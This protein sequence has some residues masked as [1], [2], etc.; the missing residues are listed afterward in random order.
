MRMT[1]KRL[2]AWMLTLMMIFSCVSASAVDGNVVDYS[3]STSAYDVM[4]QD[5]STSENITIT[6]VVDNEYYVK[7]PNSG[8]T[9]LRVLRTDAAAF[10][11]R[12]L[13]LVEWSGQPK[14]WKIASTGT[15]STYSI[16]SGSTLKDAGVTL[17]ALDVFNCTAVATPQDGYRY[18]S[19]KSWV[20]ES[21][22]VCNNTTVFTED[23]T[24]YLQL[25]VGS[26]YYTI[27]FVCG[28][29]NHSIATSG[30]FQLGQTLAEN[31]MTESTVA[32]NKFTSDFCT[33]GPASNE[34]LSAWQL[35]NY[36]T[37]SRVNLT[38]GL[39]ITSDYATTQYGS[40]IKAYAVWEPGVGVT[41]KIGNQYAT[42]A[43]ETLLVKPGAK[44]GDIQ[45][46]PNPNNYI[47]DTFIGWQYT[48]TAG[49]LKYAT[50]DTVISA[51]MEFNA[52]FGTPVY[53]RFQYTH[54]DETTQG[55]VTEIVEERARLSGDALGTLPTLTD[56]GID[57][58]VWQYTDSNNVVQIATADTVITADTYFTAVTET[59]Q[60]TATF[61]YVSAYDE[62]TGAPVYT[63]IREQTLNAGAALGDA[64][65]D[66]SEYASEYW[67]FKGWQ[68]TDST[69]AIQTA[70]PDT[71]IT[72]NTTFTALFGEPNYGTVVF[73]DILPN[74]T[75]HISLDFN[76]VPEGK[77]LA[78][79][80]EENDK[81]LADA[82]QEGEED[83]LISECV[84]RTVDGDLADLT[85]VVTADSEI[86]LYTHTYQIVLT[87]NPNTVSTAAF[88]SRTRASVDPSTAE[89]GTITMT[90]TARE[91]EQLTENDFIVNGTDLTQYAWTDG[92][93]NAINLRSLIDEGVTGSITAESDGTL[94]AEPESGFTISFQI[95]GADT[96]IHTATV[97]VGTNL[98]NWIAENGETKTS[99]IIAGNAV[100]LGAFVW[101]NSDG[102]EITTEQTV[103][104]DVTVVGT[105]SDVTVT[106]YND[107]KMTEPSVG[108]VTLSYGGTVSGFPS[109]EQLDVPEGM[110]FVEWR[111]RG[112]EGEVRFDS[113]T[114]VY[115]NM[116]VYAYYTNVHTLT[117]YTDSEM[118]DEA[119]TVQV[120]HGG[121]FNTDQYPTVTP[122][123]GQTLRYW[124]YVVD[125]A[126]Q[127]F[128]PLLPVTADM[129]LYPV[130]DKYVFVLKDTDTGKTI[131][132]IYAGDPVNFAVDA[133]E[134][135][136]YVGVMLDNG[137]TI[138]TNG[139]ETAST[140][141]FKVTEAVNGQYT[142]NVT[143]V[144]EKQLTVVYHAGEGATIL[145]ANGADTYTQTVDASVQMPGALDIVRTDSS[146]AVALSGWATT[147]DATTVLYAA[148]E[149]VTNERLKALEDDGEIHL[150]PVWSP[151][152]D[153]VAV[154][155]VSNYPE[156]AVDANGNKLEEVRYTIYIKSGA[157]PVMPTLAQAGMVT[158]SNVFGENNDQQRYTLS[159]WSV[160]PTG[161]GDNTGTVNGAYV[162]GSQYQAQINE[163]TEFY[164]IWIDADEASVQTRAY[165]YIR[166]DG[167]IPQEPGGYSK[168]D[169]YP[170]GS[171]TTLAGYIKKPINIVNDPNKVALNIEE[172][173]SADEIVNMLYYIRYS[174]KESDGWGT[175]GENVT[176][177][178]VTLLPEDYGTTWW[179][180]WY[181]CKDRADGVNFNV[182]GRIRLANEYMVTYMPNGGTSANMPTSKLYTPDTNVTVEYRHSTNPDNNGYPIREGYTFLGWDTNPD[183]ETPMYP[184]DTDQVFKMPANDVVLYAIWKPDTI[185][186]S[187]N[188]LKYMLENNEE[189]PASK[190]FNF[191][192]EKQNA[193]GSY[194]TVSTL[195]NDWWGAFSFDY[196]F[197]SSGLHTFRVTEVKGDDTTI[198]YDGAVY[199]ITVY[200]GDG[201][202]GLY[203]VGRTVMK[204][205]VIQ[206]DTTVKF[207][208]RVG[209]RDVTVTKVWNDNNDQD[210]IRPSSITVSLTQDGDSYGSVETLT[211]ANG[212]SATWTGLLIATNGTQHVYNVI[213]TAAGVG[214]T[215]ET[216]GSMDSGFTITNTHAPMT[217]DITVKKQWI[218]NSDAAK[219][220]PDNITLTLTGSD[221]STRTAVLT[222]TGNDWTHTFTGL[223]VYAGGVPVTY[224]LDET[225]VPAGYTKSVNG[226]TVTN[227]LQSYDFTVNKRVEGNF[228]SPTKEFSF[229]ANI[230]GSDKQT[231]I[232]TETFT[233]AHNGSKIIENIPH[234]AYVQVTENPDGYEAKHQFGQEV[235]NGA[236]YTAA[237]PITN[238]AQGVTFINTKNV[239]VDTGINLDGLPYA[240]LLLGV[241]GIA[242]V[243]LLLYLGRR[244]ED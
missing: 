2:T 201:D 224:T 149:V 6:F 134:G 172:G 81:G 97:P 115:E 230:L 60:V 225:D 209:T 184:V 193:D 200:I 164:A 196:E 3:D 130:F 183:A 227:T 240:L 16:P 208:N 96:P 198:A 147:A 214:Y 1:L 108:T 238:D 233:L 50:E 63:P 141:L 19:L 153:A 110:S 94:A 23:T 232:R 65:P 243:W 239:T 15:V 82:T 229:T 105:L 167:S 139:E 212:W 4:P 107:S 74:G 29:D 33:H 118:T 195:K 203:E 156:D 162:V 124:V 120:A 100:K 48:D 116:E 17:P 126:V 155:F 24:L 103:D 57:S 30:P 168:S 175:S 114:P 223:P 59:P 41:F 27:D 194:T 226:Y 180:E 38:T 150:Y 37:G 199:T 123:A 10:T 169:Y 43:T 231:V 113:S 14:W 89:D 35:H 109:V 125:G 80:I 191:L 83:T 67:I 131:T 132:S 186:L 7:D 163:N 165:F 121:L 42:I 148:S 144:F 85:A 174:L 31:Y 79:A 205:N 9:H 36:T 178:G 222:G 170:L 90:I 11:D 25:S 237:Q 220:R 142:V 52:I 46:I 93:G 119:G 21:G 176:Y 143:P 77:T 101:K 235:G 106:F 5:D 202:Q 135:Y 217:T 34:V 206:S 70:T 87:L 188:G 72:A 104:A 88:T 171:G 152:Y 20:T 117:F 22:T 241:V 53:A 166:S 192:V 49:N 244:K 26:I 55:N 92:N 66:V 161:R 177:K 102:E 133:P 98:Y 56:Y 204:N 151:A 99:H 207:V 197:D 91:G 158:P 54:F 86:H 45:G 218:D 213:E 173:P 44:F 13:K 39:E 228:A 181:A 219:V 112:T 128:N 84:W 140:D 159:G 189:S 47:K 64:L 136:Y 61:Q 18:N 68:Y 216:T 122:P 182:D 137:T 154:T 78:W 111:Y 95:S 129:S 157:K 12:T 242:V 73:H 190:S 8:N 145:A 236:S 187:F 32:A 127:V 71:V 234:G 185:V 211:A 76:E 179:V 210:G 62:T 221:G 40:A 146:S 28:E 75:E 160:D 138:V 58:V 215:S 69:G 51:G